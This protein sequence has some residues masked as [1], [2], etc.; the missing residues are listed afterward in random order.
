VIKVFGVVVGSVRHIAQK[1]LGRDG[2]KN[3]YGKENSRQNNGQHKRQPVRFWRNKGELGL[4][5]RRKVFKIRESSLAT[6][7]V[8]GEGC[9][10]APYPALGHTTK[11]MYLVEIEGQVATV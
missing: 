6:R 9:K 5:S 4:T 3:F 1:V 11:S 8:R 2:R 10:L 7:R